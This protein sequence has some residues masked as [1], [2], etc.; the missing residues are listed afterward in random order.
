MLLSSYNEYWY[1]RKLIDIDDSNSSTFTRI[2]F[3]AF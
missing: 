2:Y 1:K 3:H